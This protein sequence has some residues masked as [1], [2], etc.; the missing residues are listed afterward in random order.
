MT[1]VW[2]SVALDACGRPPTLGLPVLWTW[3]TPAAFAD[4]TLDQCHADLAAARQ[5]AGHVCTC[6]VVTP[7]AAATDLTPHD[8]LVTQAYGVV[9]FILVLATAPEWQGR[10]LGSA[11]LRAITSVADR[12]QVSCANA[13][14]PV[15]IVHMLWHA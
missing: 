4:G 1:G 2:L 8:V 12:Q 15:C 6:L 7:A 14:S 11:A 5:L 10:G 9:L 13:V 3:T